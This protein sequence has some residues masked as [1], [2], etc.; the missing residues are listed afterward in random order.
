MEAAGQLMT[1]ISLS[2]NQRQEYDNWR[3]KKRCGNKRGYCSFAC[4][5]MEET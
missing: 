1:L 2:V 5:K 4:S 3:R